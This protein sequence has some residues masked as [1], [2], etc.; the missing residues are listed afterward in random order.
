[1]T[2]RQGPPQWALR[3]LAVL[4]Q[5]PHL[6]SCC[7][8]AAAAAACRAFLALPGLGVAAAGRFR[9]PL[10]DGPPAASPG[11]CSAPASALLPSPPEAQQVPPYCCAPVHTRSLARSA[12]PGIM[13]IRVNLG[14]R[15]LFCAGSAH[16][17]L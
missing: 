17:L 15:R 8:A 10:G 4:D 1:M 13:S 14:R 9:W 3:S 7:P 11:A 6:C 2:C 12:S 5:E 16:A